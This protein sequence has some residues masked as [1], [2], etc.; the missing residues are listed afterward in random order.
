LIC[1]WRNVDSE[2]PNCDSAVP[3]K[4]DGRNV[5]RSRRVYTSLHRPTHRDTYTRKN[6]QCCYL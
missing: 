6:I 2:L 3:C 1:L 5:W 4:R